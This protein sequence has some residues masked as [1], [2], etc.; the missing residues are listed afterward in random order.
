PGLSE[1][2]KVHALVDR[3]LEH[4]R[5]FRFN[6]GGS[7]EVFISSADW[8]PRNFHRRVELL[9]PVLDPAIRRQVNEI[10][11]ILYADNSKTWELASDGGY[12]RFSPGA[13]VPPT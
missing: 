11:G 9:V 7:E 13:G 3:F 10:M 4:A 6:N 5:V 8:M 12:S 1:R 2:I